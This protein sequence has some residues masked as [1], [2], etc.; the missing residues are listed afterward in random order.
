LNPITCSIG[1]TNN[2]KYNPSRRRVRVR[3]R[4]KGKEE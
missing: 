1:I 4:S 3:N 2:M